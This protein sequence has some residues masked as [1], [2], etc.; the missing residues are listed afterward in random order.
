M[1]STKGFSLGSIGGVPLTI[2]AGWLL[3]AALLMVAFTPVV[4]TRLSL[5][6]FP[7][8]GVALTIPI[9]L[10]ASVLIHELAHGLTAQ[11]LGYRV[12]EYVITLWGGHTTFVTEID[13]PAAAALVAGAGPFANV[14]LAG[15]G[16]V[17]MPHVGP[18]AAF[19]T[20][21]LTL[22]NGFVA[23]FNLLPASPLDGGKILEALIWKISGKRWLAMRLA[24]R[25][26]QV[27]AVAVG[28]GFLAWP[29]AIG[30]TS[31]LTVITGVIV[32][33]VM[34]QGASQ[35]I[36]TAQVRQASEDFTLEPYLR[37]VQVISPHTPIS[38]VESMPAF[39]YERHHN[40]DV[41]H[42]IDPQAWQTVPPSQRDLTPASA[43]QTSQPV[44]I[45]STLGGSPAVTQLAH[46]LKAGNRIFLYSPHPVVD[47]HKV[48]LI[49]L[50]AVLAELKTRGA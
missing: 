33:M 15:I 37:S 11:S 16:W 10:A 24:G 9:L 36:K 35:T 42:P 13:R 26:G 41:F 18:T 40:R 25:L 21:T 44:G 17:T 27:C 28:L 3:I 22:T 4:Q 2:T 46:G 23:V 14:I 49:E 19:I 6:I 31:P 43:V 47:P 34:W 29:Y 50:D 39:V 8:A 12:R 45:I 38:R 7:A 1:R 32:A 48:A 5:P 30:T 20:L